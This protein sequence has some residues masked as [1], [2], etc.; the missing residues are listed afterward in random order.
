[1]TASI[2]FAVTSMIHFLINISVLVASC[3]C[4]STLIAGMVYGSLFVPAVLL[5]RKKN[6]SKTMSIM[7]C[8][9]SCCLSFI[10][11]FGVRILDNLCHEQLVYMSFIHGFVVPG[12]IVSGVRFT[13][14]KSNK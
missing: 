11:A 3:E 12:M 8:G 7:I 1:M 5:I 6:Q 13:T 10:G 14:I 4:L 9:V 2:I